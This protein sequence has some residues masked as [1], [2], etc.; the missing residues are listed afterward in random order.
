MKSGTLDRDILWETP[1][2]K[3]VSIKSRRL[4]AKEPSAHLDSDD[5]R[6]AKPF[7]GRVL[8][9]RTSYSKERRIL[10]CH[11]TGRSK[12]IL[13]CASETALETTCPHTYKTRSGP[14]LTPGRMVEG[15]KKLASDWTYDVVSIG[16]PGPVLGGRPIAEPYNLGRGWVG[17]DFA[18]AFGRP[19]KLVNDAAMQA[20]RNKQH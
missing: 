7:S 10:L 16:Y 15:V 20:G 5:P 18:H 12:L 9:P 17:Y 11:A 19:V 14:T 3:H 8:H 13:A 1:A 2:G 4:S 6:L